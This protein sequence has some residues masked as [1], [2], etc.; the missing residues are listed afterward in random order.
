[1]REELDNKNMKIANVYLE[2][3]MLDKFDMYAK[4]D[5]RKRSEVIRMLIRKYLEEKDLEELEKK[6][7]YNV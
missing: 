1:M 2:K 6:G 4:K 3:D 7:E 5:F